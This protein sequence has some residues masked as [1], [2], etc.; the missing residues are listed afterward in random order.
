MCLCYTLVVWLG[1]ILSV[2][3][4]VPNL[5]WSN[6]FTGYGTVHSSEDDLLDSLG[7]LSSL[8]LFGCHFCWMDLI[9]S[10]GLDSGSVSS[11]VLKTWLTLVRV[12]RV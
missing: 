10:L 7:G 11:C 4:V 1:T 9:F 2:R 5:E 12:S 8:G 3:N 6:M